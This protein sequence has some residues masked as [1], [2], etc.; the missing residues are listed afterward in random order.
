[1]I[2]MVVLLT[3]NATW[4]NI[5]LPGRL[6]ATYN[7]IKKLVYILHPEYKNFLPDYMMSHHLKIATFY[8]SAR[9]ITG[10]LNYL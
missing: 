6:P 2:F 7:K 4:Q 10:N 9:A 8:H 5:T 1:M 3:R